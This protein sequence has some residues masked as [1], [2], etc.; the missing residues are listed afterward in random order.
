[1]TKTEDRTLRDLAIDAYQKAIIMKLLNYLQKNK[2]WEPY[3]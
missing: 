3:L 1:M 2:Y